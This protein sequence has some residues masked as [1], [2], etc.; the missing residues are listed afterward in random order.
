MIK[1]NLSIVFLVF[2][3]FISPFNAFAEIGVGVGVGKMVMDKPLAPGGVYPL[4]NLPVINTGDEYSQYTVMVE[5][6]ENVEEMRP[7]KNWFSFDPSSFGIE[8]GNSQNVNIVL[9]IPSDAAPGDYFAFLQAQ[10]IK[11]QEIIDNSNTLVNIAAA[12][13]FYFTIAS[14]NIF[15]AAFYKVLTLYDLLY[16]YDAM[17]LGFII[18][19]ILTFIIKKKFNIKIS[20]KRKKEDNMVE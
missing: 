2:L 4:P 17:V 11:D 13:K 6:R 15:Q 20:S 14:S 10:P 8:P 3:F 9:T 5:Y 7:G 12:S 16:P 1:R 18:F 19:V